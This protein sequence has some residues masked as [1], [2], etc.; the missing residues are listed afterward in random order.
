M[1]LTSEPS[2][3]VTRR[4]IVCVAGKLGSVFFR[5]VMIACIFRSG[6]SASA[7]TA[8]VPGC[9][10]IAGINVQ[11]TEPRLTDGFC[12]SAAT[13]TS[14]AARAAAGTPAVAAGC[15]VAAAVAPVV[16]AGAG[17]AAGV[18]AAGV[19]SAEDVGVGAGVAAA[20]SPTRSTILAALAGDGVCA[21]SAGSLIARSCGFC[22]SR[23]AATATEIT[24]PTTT[25]S[26]IQG[27]G[28]ARGASKRLGATGRI[29]SLVRGRGRVGDP[30]DARRRVDRRRL[31]LDVGRLVA[32]G[33]ERRRGRL[34]ARARA[35]AERRRRSGEGGAAGAGLASGIGRAGGSTPIDGLAGAP[36][37]G[38]A[39][40]RGAAGRAD[41]GSAGRGARAVGGAGA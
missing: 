37:V 20:P 27:K 22:R 17:V 26:R 39:G 34:V 18:S 14:I 13:A 3:K 2:P 16:D 12:G 38:A 8:I 21:V 29:E 36:I 19:A 15:G 11:T 23:N 31:A 32:R 1:P 40:A 7:F 35:T 30:I 24:T 41:G 33:D 9:P 6:I 10:G 4:S 28:L 25:A 5:I